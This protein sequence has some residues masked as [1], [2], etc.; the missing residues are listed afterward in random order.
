ME[1]TLI[2]LLGP[3]GVGKSDA[4]FT[5]AVESGCDI[6][7]CD[8][9]QFYRGMSIGTAVP[10]P[11][12]LESVRHHFI[13][14]LPPESYYSSSLF[15]RDVLGL[16]PSLFM[17]NRTVLMTGGSMLYIDTVCNGTDDIPDIDSAVREKWQETWLREGTES[18]VRSLRELD[19]EHY[20]KVDLRN[21][22]R[23]IR[24]LEIC[25]STGKPYSSFLSKGSRKRDFRII[26]IGL[27]RDREEL[28]RRINH[29]V[30]AM[31]EAGLVEEAR[32]MLPWRG[33]NALNTVGYRELFS[34]FDG[35]IT[36]EEAISLI[37]RNTRHYAKRQL[38]WWNRDKSIIWIGADDIESARSY[39]LSA[40]A[41]G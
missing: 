35:H 11:W 3:T 40:S 30:D 8:S 38:T 6:I 24:A 19:P 29:R 13:Q 9:R 18:L 14:F 39:M 5:L 32:N 16:L 31:I 2:V 22:R 17:K 21:H 28:Y 27:R 7:S 4:A 41:T 36:L 1:N 25:E 37:K 33:L 23:I 15:E 10:P 20:A 34:Y 12:Q 26:K